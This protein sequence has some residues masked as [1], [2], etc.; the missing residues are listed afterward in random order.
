MKKLNLPAECPSE[1]IFHLWAISRT[2]PAVFN[3]MTVSVEVFNE[4]GLIL[5][6]VNER[7]IPEL[8][9]KV[10]EHIFWIDCYISE[11][12]FETGFYD[13]DTLI[14]TSVFIKIGEEEYVR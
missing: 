5:A 12:I 1:D 11:Q 2:K 13:I 7:L 14:A 4:A 9:N 6:L 10:P 8:I 3:S